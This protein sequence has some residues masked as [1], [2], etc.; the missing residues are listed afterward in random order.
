MH[1]FISKLLDKMKS[2]S[3]S[4]LV[5]WSKVVVSEYSTSRVWVYPVERFWEYVPSPETEQWCRFFGYG[6]EE[7]RPA[8]FQIGDT[9]YMHPSIA[10]VMVEADFV[11]SA[12][13]IQS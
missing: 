3:S 8:C 9:L 13:T 6:H 7:V 1:P 11:A 10:R 2:L 4:C 12:I 5:S